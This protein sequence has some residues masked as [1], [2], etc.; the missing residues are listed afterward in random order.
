M[1]AMVRGSYHVCTVARGFVCCRRGRLAGQGWGGARGVDAF[2]FLTAV[3]EPHTDHFL[4]HVKLLSHQQDLLRGWL[5][6]LQCD[7]KHLELCF[8]FLVDYKAKEVNTFLVILLVYKIAVNW[9]YIFWS[10]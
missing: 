8:S 2:L 3:A 1:R 6:V 9:N 10:V 7:R 5:L 4:F